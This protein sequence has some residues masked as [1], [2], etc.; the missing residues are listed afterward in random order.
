MPKGSGTLK[1]KF[2]EL[3]KIV[4]FGVKL[5]GKGCKTTFSTLPN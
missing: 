4:Y 5:G 2:Y 1:T 3:L